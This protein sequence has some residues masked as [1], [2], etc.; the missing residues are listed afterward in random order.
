MDPIRI[1]D[2]SAFLARDGQWSEVRFGFKVIP[3]F[4]INIHIFIINL[5]RSEAGLQDEVL[6][7][8]PGTEE[9]DRLSVAIMSRDPRDRALLISL[10]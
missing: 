2:R 5:Q 9:V 1:D 4:S 8:C 6:D 10:G 7:S 3:S